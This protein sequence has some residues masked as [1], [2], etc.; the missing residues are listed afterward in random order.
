MTPSLPPPNRSRSRV[1]G[2][3]GCRRGWVGLSGD[4][5][6]YFGR[7]IAELVASAELDGPVAV[8]GIDIPI[9]LP[10]A[11]PRRADVLARAVV[12]RRASSV[13]PTPAREALA[14]PTHAEA[15]AISVRATGRGLS[16]QAF[17]L[18]AKI[19]EVD[20]WSRTVAQPVIE[21]H[22]EVSFATMAG[23][24]LRHPKSTWA[25][26]EERRRVLGDA[27]VDLP[28]PLGLAGEMA[29]PDDVLDA[30]A[31]AWTAARYRD[32]RAASFPS[33]PEDLGDG[34]AAAIWA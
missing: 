16:Q 23:R 18:R 3:D 32:G 26:A 12:G 15:T 34:H 20:A 30:L 19:L 9:G 6:G 28:G 31:V 1:V 13:F 11:G 7:T 8:V 22:P 5:H 33:D 17:A 25:G 29:G 27:G 2:V 4:G 21:V 10:V 14:A 24:P